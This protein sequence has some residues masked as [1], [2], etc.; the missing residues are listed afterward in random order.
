MKALPRLPFNA[1]RV[2][3]AVARHGSMARAAEALN[4]LPSAASMQMK[5]LSGYVGV[6]LVSAP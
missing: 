5:N 6:P 4:V 1:L 3:E 2:F